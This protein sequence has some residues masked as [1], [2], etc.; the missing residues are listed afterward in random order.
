MKE[1]NTVKVRLSSVIY[2][3]IIVLLSVALYYFGFVN[4]ANKV[5]YFI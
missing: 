4:K 3:I 2:I 1:D 5:A